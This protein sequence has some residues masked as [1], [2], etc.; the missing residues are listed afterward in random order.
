MPGLNIPMD[1]FFCIFSMSFLKGSK[2]KKKILQPSK[3]SQISNFIRQTKPFTIVV[4]S[5]G[6]TLEKKKKKTIHQHQAKGIELYTL[7][8]TGQ[9]FDTL[10]TLFNCTFILTQ[11]Q[12]T[13][14]Q[15]RNCNLRIIRSLF[16]LIRLVQVC[17]FYLFIQKTSCFVFSALFVFTSSVSNSM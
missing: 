1:Q 14:K 10:E 15:L 11:K 4:K 9:S 5:I 6:R 13:L 2:K 17:I 12:E 7:L 16:C 3:T 8:Y